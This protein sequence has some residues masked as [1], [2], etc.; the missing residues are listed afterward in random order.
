MNLSRIYLGRKMSVESRQA[1]SHKV[2]QVNDL[3]FIL[4]VMGGGSLKVPS[5][6]AWK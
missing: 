6:G 5:H 4:Q 1:A 3:E 2:G